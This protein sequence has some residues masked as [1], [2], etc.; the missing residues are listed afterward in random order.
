MPN[1]QYIKLNCRKFPKFGHVTAGPAKPKVRQ[2]H[3]A[4][5]EVPN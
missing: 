4:S 3:H 5:H 2:M 1:I